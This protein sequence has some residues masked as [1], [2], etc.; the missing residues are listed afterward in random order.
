MSRRPTVSVV[1][2]CY[3]SRHVF[4]QLRSLREQTEPADELI[5]VDDST[6]GS[7]FD[8]IKEEL[9][10]HTG[11]VVVEKNE[12][13]LGMHASYTFG[14]GL[15]TC[16][17]VA[18]CDH[19][20]VWMPEKLQAIRDAMLDASV[21]GLASDA[22]IFRVDAECKF[23]VRN[24]YESLLGRTGVSKRLR[25]RA[26]DIGLEQLL[27]GNIFS[28]ATLAFRRSILSDALPLP[29]DFL[30]DYWLV[31]CAAASGRFVLI[32]RPLIWYRLHDQNTVGVDEEKVGL[33]RLSRPY[34]EYDIT[35][36][37][38][39][40]R[41]WPRS[42]ALVEDWCW[43]MNWR[44]VLRTGRLFDLRIF[45]RHPAKTLRSARYFYINI[46]GVAADLCRLAVLLTRRQPMRISTSG[47]SQK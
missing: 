2:S 46:G 14:L 3:N 35:T 17:V 32:P 37:N 21:V 36:I 7:L 22:A 41:S 27:R 8:L 30:P 23:P 42:I 12:T 44:R 4:A 28:G 13:N 33:T 18:T 20:D 26:G 5:V 19:D 16:D 43:F 11:R 47:P 31:L 10:F 29:S 1:L 40:K 34:P 6:D 9:R 24:N 38:R 39:M 25:S 45:A 15:V